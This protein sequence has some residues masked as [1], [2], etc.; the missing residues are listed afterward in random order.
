M[1]MCATPVIFGRAASW[2][3][4]RERG[5]SMAPIHLR[6]RIAMRPMLL[7]TLPFEIPEPEILPASAVSVTRLEA[8]ALGH[9]DRRFV[10]ERHAE[11]RVVG[12]GFERGVALHLELEQ[13]AGPQQ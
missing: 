9:R 2:A 12:A 11:P 1:P 6:E 5:A 3:S 7:L 13:R 10:G 8:A 4:R